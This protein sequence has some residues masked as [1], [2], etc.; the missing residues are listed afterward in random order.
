MLADI[1]NG[2]VDAADVFFLIAA[3]AA[4]IAAVLYAVARVPRRTT[5]DAR[6]VYDTAGFAP[7][8]GWLAVAC[9]AFGFMLL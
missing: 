5:T 4:A 3:I 7:A 6:V 9:V 1:A 8:L 2:N